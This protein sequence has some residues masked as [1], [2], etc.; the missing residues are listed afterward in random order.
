M[1]NE[2]LFEWI[3]ANLVTKKY[4]DEKLDEMEESIVR[5]VGAVGAE[6]DIHR[7]DPNAHAQAAE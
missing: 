3:K 4:L 6:L 1:S 2:E 7:A 5:R